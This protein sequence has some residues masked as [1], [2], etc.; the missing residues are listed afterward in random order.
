MALHGVFSV[1]GIVTGWYEA[2]SEVNKKHCTHNAINVGQ[3]IRVWHLLP[4]LGCAYSA[5]HLKESQVPHQACCN[6]DCLSKA[7]CEP[8][9]DDPASRSECQKVALL[10]R[11]SWSLQRQAPPLQSCQ[12]IKKWNTHNCID[13]ED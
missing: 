13:L 1:S 12:P 8:H 11:A 7:F 3:C 10:E 4:D 9:V 2:S 6:V 5:A